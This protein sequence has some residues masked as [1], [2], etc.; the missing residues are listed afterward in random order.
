MLNALVLAH[1]HLRLG[2]F[3]GSA[4]ALVFAF[5]P[6]KSQGRDSFQESLIK[7]GPKGMSPA[8]KLEINSTILHAP[9]ISLR[10]LITQA[11]G[12]EDYQLSGVSG[13]ME[14][15]TYAITAKAEAPVDSAEMLTML[16]THLARIFRLRTHHESKVA[17][18]F[19]L[20]VDKSGSKLVPLGRDE[21]WKDSDSSTDRPAMIIGSSIQEL[22]GYLNSDR[23]PS[24]LGRPVVDRTGLRD[25]Y[26]IRLVFRGEKDPETPRILLNI[27][28]PSALVLQLGLRLET[29]TAAMD[30]LV[31]DNAERPVLNR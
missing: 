16:R 9:C 27:D 10:Y 31:I 17:P 11:F 28:Y 19:A 22:V 18:A 29:T 30:V 15:D 4:L 23:G 25:L 1:A 26:K 12:V 7:R 21:E 20:R 6:A 3:V 2:V 8:P 13:W 24:A 5:V 14:S